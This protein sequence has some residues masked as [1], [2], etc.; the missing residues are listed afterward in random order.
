M[1]KT[2]LESPFPKFA[3]LITRFEISGELSRK[4]SVQLRSGAFPRSLIWMTKRPETLLAL[5][6]DIIA[7]QNGEE[8]YV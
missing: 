5:Y 4:R 8:Q 2:R 3:T 1:P 6:E 7:Q